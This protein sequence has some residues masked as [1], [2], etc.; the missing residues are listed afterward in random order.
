MSVNALIATARFHGQVV[1]ERFESGIPVQVGG[2]PPFSLPLPEGVDWL[3]EVDWS[4][5]GTARVTDATGQRYTLGPDETLEMELGDIAIDL[6][7]APQFRLRRSEA[8]SWQLSTGWLV[9]VLLFTIFTS[10]YDLISSRTCQIFAVT[11]ELAVQLGCVEADGGGGEGRFSAD[12]LARLLKEDYAGEE[13][14]TL[15]R[16]EQPDDARS[17]DQIY[18]PSG[19]RGPIS[20][21]GGAEEVAPESVKAP[22]SEELPEPE[23][24]EAA[25]QNVL[26]VPELPEDVGTVIEAIPADGMGEKDEGKGEDA[27]D[28]SD[29]ATPEVAAEEK[30]GWGLQDWYDERDAILDKMEIDQTVNLAERRLKIDPNDPDALSLLSYY[31][32]LD[33]D[34][35]SAEKTYDRLIEL[36]PEDAAGFNNKALIYKR[37]GDYKQE[38]ALY[39]VALALEPM[40]VTALN[41]L[42]VN[43]AHQGRHSEA[44]SVMQQ[45]EILDPDDAYADLHRAKIYAEMGNDEKAMEYL[46]LSLEGMAK[47]DTLHHI[48]FRQDIRLDPSFAKLRETKR[49]RAILLEFYGDD[50]PVLE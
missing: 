36:L 14:G 18:L 34:Y 24:Q 26:Q 37:R 13:D 28:A 16:P 4:R 3:A 44:L 21:M 47:L 17:N 32:Y 10:W 19:G 41:N 22:R 33:E 6:E 49:F 46:R 43:L 48:E 42:G 38:E 39:R 31:Q 27:D 50:A 11:P 2:A 30:E 35:E 40:D 29:E 15:Q 7:L 5:D 23:K 12:Y 8:V 20:D 1:Q 25:E 9:V 45:L